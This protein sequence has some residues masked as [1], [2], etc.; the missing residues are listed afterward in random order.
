MWKELCAFSTEGHPLPVASLLSNLHVEKGHAAC[1]SFVWL[2]AHGFPLLGKGVYC[3]TLLSLG[4]V[5]HQRQ[6]NVVSELSKLWKPL[7]QVQVLAL[8]FTSS[9]MWASYSI[10][11]NRKTG[12]ISY[13]QVYALKLQ[14]LI[15]DLARPWRYR[16]VRFRRSNRCEVLGTGP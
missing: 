3:L 13:V 7:T 8:P 5:P 15:E 4:Y 2:H 11:M 16:V 12:I 1:F 9:V 14:T 6:Y 10:S